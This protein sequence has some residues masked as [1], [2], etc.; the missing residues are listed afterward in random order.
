[1]NTIYRLVFNRALRVWQVASELVKGGGGLVGHVPGR[2][3]AALSP[4]GFAL[5]CS[6]GWVSLGTPALAQ[7]DARIISDPNAPGRERP[8][9]VTA[10][11]GVP[12]VNITTPSAAGVSRNR[13]SQF[14]VGRDG[15]ILNNARGQ[16]QT[17]LG[18]WVQG[19]P[20]LATGS[21]R[22][23][24]N[25]VNGPA[26]R[27]NG[28]V[29]VAGQRAEVIIANPAGIQVNGGGFLNASRVTLTTGTPMFTGAGA[30]E[31]Y[32]V[33]GGAIQI[34]GQ[35]LDTS[36]AD[37]TDL[38]TRSL[39]VNAGIWANQL[40]ATLGNNV[41]SADHSQASATA[42]SGEAPAFALDVG[43]LGGMFANKIWLVGN[44]HGVG[45]RNAG[46]IGAQAGEL[47]VTVDGRLENTGALQ[48][49]QNVRVQARGDLANAGTIAATR[50]VAID[51][52]GTLDNSGGKLNAQRLRVEAQGLRNHGGTIEQTGVQALALK[53]DAASN[54]SNGL[55][56]A[57]DA[58][59][60]GGNGSG[61]GGGTLPGS[62]GGTPGTGSPGTGTPGAG[63]GSTG[64]PTSP[65]VP[66][67]EGLI[68]I[69]GTLDNDGGSIS[70]GGTVSLVARNG[71]DNSGGRLG[72]SAL[73]A[74]GE[75]RNDG[76]ML[77]VHGDA[78]L[79]V[80][81]LSNQKGALSVAG[82]LWLDAQSLDNRGGEL[83]H[84]GK[85]ASS[86]TV[87]GLFNNDGGLLATN[88][89]RLALR[90]GQVGNAGGRIEHAGEGGLQLGTGDWA[91]AG[92]HLSTLGRL[93]W[94]VGNADLRNG[95]LSAAGFEILAATLDNRGG[96]LLSL[97]SG[98]SSVKAA[99]LDNSARGTLAGNGDLA[100]V[101]T[102]LDN[103]NGLVQQAGT[104]TLSVQA[105]TLRG[106]EGRLLSNGA[107]VLSGGELDVSGGTTSA[108]SVQIHAGALRNRQGQIVSQG[109]SAL[110]LDVRHAFDNQGGQIVGNGGLRI[111]A[112][113]IDNQK[114]TLQSAGTQGLVLTV[115]DSLGNT[116]GAISGNGQ[117][118]LQADSLVN[119]GGKVLAAGS[120][121]LQVQVRELLDNSNGGRL[122]GTGDVQLQA[123]RLDNRGGA[124]EHAGRGTLQ[125]RADSL[126][127]AAGRI[128]SQ[129]SLTLE[130]GELVLG[131]GSVTQAERTAIDAQRLDNAGGSLSATG[132]EALLVRVAQALD[133]SGGTIAG[134]GALDVQ[135]GELIN[136]KG[137][138]SGAGT[139]DSTLQIVAALDNHEGTIASNA[140]RLTV[141]SARLDNSGGSIR[142]AGNQGLDI[143]TG[144]LDGSKGT[145]VSSATLTLR[146]GDVDHRDATLGADRLDLEATTLDNAGGR[147]IASGE[148][149]SRIKATTLGNAGGTL[150]SNGD[151]A[152]L[153]QVLDNRAG[154]IQHAGSGQ[155]Q[156][157][158]KTLLGNG[159]SV[160][161]NGSFALDGA[162]LD[163]TAATTSARRVDIT[164]DTLTT[165]GG[166]LTATGEDALRL[167]VQGVLDN[168]GGSLASN[169]ALAV[170]AQQLI[171]AQGTLQG[172]GAGHSTLAIGQALDN[173][174]GRILLGGAGTVTAASLGN[175][176]G[177]VHAGGSALVLGVD[178]RLDNG[179]QGLLS[180]IGT[181][182]LGAGSLDNRHGTLVAGKDLSATTAAGVDN[183]DG[184]MQAGE[185]LQLQGNGLLNQRGTLL[186][187]QLDIDTRG[188]RLDNRAG[189][190][191]TQKGDLIVRSGAM[192]NQGGRV[193]SAADLAINTAGQDI[194]NRATAGSGG[195]LAAGKLQLDG[196]VLD[197]RGGA[198]NAQGDARLLLARVDNSSGGTLASAANLS[199][200]AASLANA[201]GRVQAGRNL[202][203]TLD[204]HLDNAD[205]AI[206]AGQLL[207]LTAASV[208]NRNTRGGDGTRGLQAGQLQFGAH[209]LDNSQGQVV[210]DGG[211]RLQIN[212]QL[213][214]TG[215]VIS[216]GGN[217]DSQADNVA[218]SGGLLR[219]DGSQTLVAR[220]LSEDGQV[221]AQR[222]LGL[223]LQQGMRHRGEW[224]ANGTLSL[225]LSGDLDNQGVVR[226]GNLDLN[227]QNITNA[228]SGEIS[229]QGTTHLNA[230]GQLTNRGLID[231]ALTH[232]EAGEIDNL[233]TGRIYGDR[234]AISTGV[235]KNRAEEAGGATR[236]GTVAARERLD[237]GVRELQN[238]GKGLIYSGGDAAIGGTLSAD[239]IASGIA[240]RIDNISSVIDVT[241]N[242]SI[243]AQVV[244]NIRENVAIAPTLVKTI[245]TTVNMM[246]AA[247]QKNSKNTAGTV[248]DT[249][250][251]KA[252][253]FYYIAPEDVLQDEPYIAPDGTRLGKAVV[254]LT[255]NTSRFFFGS[256]GLG[257]DVRGE[258]W[259]MDPVTGTVTIYYVSKGAAANPDQVPG[260]DPFDVLKSKEKFTYQ[261]DRLTFSSAYGTCST[262]CIQFI[263]PA[264]LSNPDAT[265]VG[266]R[267]H[268]QEHGLNEEKRVAHHVAHEDQ[269]QPGAGADAVIRS[270]GNMRLS[271]DELNNRYAQIAAGGNLQIVGHGA[272]S[273]VSNVGLELFRTHTFNNT[274]IAY[275]GTRTQWTAESI[276]EKI[277]QLGGQITANGTLSIDVGDLSNL[278]QGRNAPNVQNGSAMA[279]LNV[280]GPKALPDG[281]GHGGAQ[282]PGQSTGTGAER[283]LA[284]AADA[285]GTQQGGSVGGVSGNTGSSGPRVVAASGGSPDR[286][287]MGAPDTRAP[288]ASLFNVNPKGGHYL[289]ETD[290]RFTDHKTWLSS[291]HLL[292]QMGYSPDTVQKRLGDG[293]Y[294][295]K[296]VRE[297]IGQLTGRRF[298][299]GYA[300]DE[301]QY[302]ALLEAGATVASEWGLRPGV[303]LTEAQMAQLTSDIVWLVEQTV[304]LADGS[305]T[306]A[307]VPQVY[308]RLRPGDLDGNG[309]LL[310]GANVDI[311]LGNGLVNTGNIAGRKLVTIDAGNIEHLGGSISGQ[312]VGLSS[313]KDIRVVGAAVTATDA[314]SV[315]AAGNV[316]V[317]STVETQQGG[318][319]Y[320]YETNRI[321]RVAGL[322]VTN[323]S[324]DGMLSV[325]AG[326]D[327]N[328]QAAQIRNAGA[329]GLTQLA[330][331]GTLDVGAIALEERRDATFDERNHQRSSRTTHAASSVQGAGDV[332]L[333]AG[334]DINLAAA[335]INAG[336]G[337]ALQAGDDINS[338][339]LVDSESRDFA[340]AGKRSSL[341]VSQ[342]DET[343][344]GSTLQAGDNL[345]LNAGRDVN[346]TA[347]LVDSNDGAVSVA[348]GRDVNLLSANET[349]DYSL[350]SYDKKKKTLSS[351]TTTRSVDASDSYAI[352]TAIQGERINITAGR[353]LTAVGAV[354]DATG[355]VIL[356]AGN[357]VLITAA[358]DHHSSESN[359]SKKK[360]GV[361]GGFGNGVAS[362]GYSSAKNNS[363]RAEQSTTQVGS[364]IASRDGNV[365]INAGNTLTIEASDVAAGENLTLVG[366]DIALLARQDTT[367]SQSSQ[368]SKS[369]GFSVGVTYD[370]TKAYRSA[371]DSTTDG[372]ADSGSAMGRITRTAEGAASGLRAAT[373]STVV[374]A[375]SQRTN[376]EQSHST[377]DAR[378]SQLAAGGDLTLIANGGSILSQGT[379]MSAEGNAVLLAT[380]NIVFDVAHNTERSDSSSRGKGWGFANNTSGLPFGTNNSQSQ[381]SGSSDTI[382]GTQLSVGGGV[383]MATTEGNISLT[384]ANIAAEKDVSIRAAGDLLVRSGQDT[385]SN[386]NTSDSKAIGTV[387]ISDTEK[388]SGWHREQHQDDSAQVSQ[389]A[390]SIGSLGGSVSLTA[391]GKY[392]QTASNVVAAKDV[393]ITAAEIE[394]LTADESGH[395]SQSDKDLKIGVFAR[396]KSPLIDLINN[397]D[398]ARQSDDRLQKM[399]GMAAGA[400]AYQAASA[401]SALSGR[402]GSGELFRAEAGIGFKTAN[403]S[404]DGSSRVSRGSS[405]QGGGNV[406]LTSTTGDIHVVQGNLS[407]GNTLSLDSAGDILLEA[408]KAHVADR[409]K[410]SNAGAEVGVGV[411]VGAQTGVYVYAE[412]SVGSSKANAESRTWQNTTLT[413]KNISMKAE[414]DTTLRGATATADRIDVKT[415]G[416]LTIE[417]LQDIAESMS[418][419]SQ[420]GGRVQVSFGTAWNADGY[421]SAGKAS[422]S[423]QGVGQQSGLFAGNGGYHVDAG[424]VNLVGGA[425]ASTHA[426]N[427]ELTAGSLTFTDLQ[428][429]MDYT[430][431]SGSISGGAGGQMD[432]WAPKPGTAAP[433][434]APG[435]PMMEKGSDSSSTLATLTEG[436][437]TIG[438]KQTSAAELGI[439]TDASGAHRALDAL[440]DASKLLADQ[441]AMAAAA[442]TVMAT[443]QQIA[444]DVQAYQSK[445]ATQAYYDG[446]SSDDKKAFNALSAEQRDAVLTAN[447]Q[448]YND[449]K[450]WG[451]GGEYSRAL[452]AVT[453][454]V[455]GGVGGQ[456]AGQVASNALAPYAA[457]FIG[458]K[459][460]SNHGSDP[461]ATLQLLSHA[462]L[463][464]LLAE[465]NGG[466]AGTGAVSAAGGELAAKVL[467]NTLTGGDPSRLSPEQKEMVL[468]LSQAVGA[469]A[470]GLSGQDLAGIALD[471][472]IA[473]NSV[474]N[475]FLGNDDH[476]RMVHL[477]EKAKRQGGLD[478]QESLELV[479]LDAADQMSAGLLRK[480]LA[481]ETLTEVQ[482]ADLATYINRYELQNGPLDLPEL[483]KQFLANSGSLNPGE[484][485]GINPSQSYGRPYV[486]LGADQKAYKDAN[487]SWFEDLIYRGKGKNERLYDAAL[488]QSGLEITR[489]ED[490]LPSAMQLR[491]FFAVHDAQASS[492]IAS[493]AFIAA[494][495]GGASEENRRALTLTMGALANIGAVR[496][497][498]R[499]GLLPQTGGLGVTRP[500]A[501]RP[502]DEASTTNSVPA[503]YEKGFSRPENS[504]PPKLQVTNDGGGFSAPGNPVQ[505]GVVLSRVNLANGRT[506]TTPLRDSGAPVSA[507]FQHVLDGHFGKSPT[508]NR[509][510]FSINPDELKVVLQSAVVVRS[511]VYEIP[512]GQYVRIVDVGRPIG[513]SSLKDGGQPTSVIKVFTDKAGNLI[514]TFP[515]K[516]GE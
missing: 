413:G 119:Q 19:N 13:Y 91:G 409:S 28:Y 398:A 84:A 215:G 137:T 496:F 217:L 60:S 372:M 57:L 105:D 403:S 354:V 101:A 272:D 185:R 299:D 323:P 23:I 443:S 459:L 320:Q 148:G 103:S 508:G 256:G 191:G 483:Q 184:A 438:G 100:L 89:T 106:S 291:D 234:V 104:G 420:V 238:T 48:S 122:A 145:L 485:Q 426:G 226:G 385:V 45:V 164:A 468:A 222:D 383:R 78:A 178:G 260:G 170:T 330:A 71:L 112:G 35:G 393:N 69:A 62:G 479:L 125:I 416:T 81:L 247:W 338:Q 484:L 26:S 297:Q 480:A 490:L 284:Q 449:A 355:N 502:T 10:P 410:S 477:R 511:P 107:L 214:N 161:S 292:G 6:L 308:L 369:S 77:Q 300:S 86:W 429:H 236:V 68:A 314:L 433:R 235:L 321:D 386:A 377:S 141:T 115:R 130:G 505:R 313:D 294:E 97:G 73:Q 37:Y 149:A 348:A 430:A 450:K 378:V 363:T 199:L 109:V 488:K 288:S 263:T 342:R 351:T 193:Q 46:S 382:T 242:L 475:N 218:N 343:V 188:Q 192:D 254:R 318:G 324:G 316:T 1:M 187:G 42:A 39:Q 407:A 282:G 437:I 309:A 270:G 395:Y 114:G 368:A 87:Q 345:L 307:L 421:A 469:L 225:N 118:Q 211:A 201:S 473:K 241:G 495:L 147:I 310:A 349:H 301:A 169:G 423:Y 347:A 61:P 419:N 74:G 391:G 322:Y 281:P 267:Q 99:T 258:R 374:T 44:E 458:S 412:A 424:H 202:D 220:T 261:N 376:S 512:G 425:I 277:G 482:A 67:A 51:T 132:S 487:Y 278:N 63:G 370:P 315:K 144:R 275:D 371:R 3:S 384:A 471:A 388:F 276:S 274:S 224:I 334:K 245:D 357:N 279:N 264:S 460:D 290:P 92:G 138:L 341:Q 392:T 453:T 486:G 25:E 326:G 442:G 162:N 158:A 457:Y 411:S 295:Q 134:N 163:L 312:Y 379:Q 59:A 293:Y 325:V 306:T 142:Q 127:G 2:Q 252:W 440:P 93:Q 408:G 151:L 152:L 146:A 259:R 271:V 435:L 498:N 506:R 53:A 387:Q 452:S 88:A 196:G 47:V 399:Q 500:R 466:S 286:I 41:V 168:R 436:N 428:N 34:D 208:D 205:G 396:V 356:G 140:N 11:N 329:D 513:I 504:N 55:L 265:I 445:K 441:Q 133:N 70:N 212:G 233:G 207:T 304:T 240:G 175:Q 176:G 444:W 183:S 32:R 54:R 15:V 29:E 364:A 85:A 14:D 177:T 248:S 102:T 251:Y 117:V 128:F 422:G 340:N 204:G 210:T 4:L 280:Q 311:K 52:G 269:L 237:L 400:N 463:G 350:D 17:Q 446:L 108:Q 273:R 244:N 219:A 470:S 200:Q 66:M 405:I 362:V 268:T 406:N 456:G 381:G 451:D 494:T 172:A 153:A 454:A 335:Q 365:L 249:S 298:L 24:L 389:V 194:D 232:L 173:Q 455:V 481:G 120:A 94:S 213:Q 352:G 404:A 167:R 182:T 96:S 206:A 497:V 123:A 266:R 516:G 80:G 358:E 227:A 431:S 439:N 143:T 464:A 339:A 448:A 216:T 499:T 139:A 171:N 476:A 305:T 332:V 375:G 491:N 366:K 110:A 359:E 243:D 303:A 373:T 18:G 402:G 198:V 113:R 209:W 156:V 317:A 126:Q 380:Q 150:A 5:M 397:V 40:Q 157:S 507:G 515:I 12:M 7:S 510:I 461:N 9:M 43:A 467:T 8:T 174:K 20:W 230:R 367:D 302:R 492:A 154:R 250:N 434:G 415:G 228:A 239:R 203:L 195:L 427:S 253:E 229:S 159:G 65:V 331:G 181:M 64:T 186:G 131:A 360:S 501:L 155:L 509:S 417:S 90:A 36:R 82:D 257:Y 418:R 79:Q 432:G 50:E 337:L 165:S 83:R 27:L 361:T 33:T 76:G 296:L 116:G 283:A 56:G 285:A 255:A 231:G 246:V 121:A 49:R 179:D 333:A 262:T 414:G 190:L 111:D 197:N 21:A 327:I 462:V 223:T 22:V 344:R 289:V 16:V 189:T 447:S 287:A 503:G 478:K 353:D 75:L 166:T 390:S 514:T 38:I 160:L 129:S 489:S 31:G 401:I 72:V 95:S 328:L 472:G 30:L 474:E 180:S 124:I 136:R 465:A 493:A 58:V 98:A 336:G 346:L 394:L 135:A 221:H 319:T